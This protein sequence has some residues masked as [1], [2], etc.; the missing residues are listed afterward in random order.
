MCSLK[1][2]LYTNKNFEIYAFVSFCNKISQINRK[3]RTNLLVQQKYALNCISCSKNKWLNQP[4]KFTAYKK[5]LLNYFNTFLLVY[6]SLIH[7]QNFNQIKSMQTE[8]KK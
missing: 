5:F 3:K 4:F 2:K 8:C 7:A 1:K 6:A